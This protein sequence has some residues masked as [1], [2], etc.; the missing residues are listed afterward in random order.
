MKN[1]GVARDEL[2]DWYETVYGDRVDANGWEKSEFRRGA[3][4]RR[5]GPMV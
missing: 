5:F 3:R 4:K 1:P 2:I